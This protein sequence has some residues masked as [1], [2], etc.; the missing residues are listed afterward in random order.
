MFLVVTIINIYPAHAILGGFIPNNYSNL[1]LV[2]LLIE[3]AGNKS[4]KVCTG[5]LIRPKTVL[6]AAHCFEG[7][8]LTKITLVRALNIYA[9]DRVTQQ[10]SNSQIFVHPE[11]IDFEKGDDFAIIKLTE[12]LPDIENLT[13]PTLTTSTNYDRYIF[14][15]YGLDENSKLGQLKK[16]FKNKDTM[17][18]TRSDEAHLIRFDQKDLKGISAGDSGGP[19]ITVVDNQAY[20]IAVS[21]QNRRVVG[22]LSGSLDGSMTKLSAP[23]IAWINSFM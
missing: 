21:S 19:V 23:T 17:L 5:T 15:G 16:V 6:T 2:A 9:G 22:G 7:A 3:I 1:P 8:G 11:Y 10:I 14:L 13:Y 12:I 18:N 4:R 20:L